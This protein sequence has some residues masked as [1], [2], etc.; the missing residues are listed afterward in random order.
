MNL[1]VC[2]IFL[3][4]MIPLKLFIEVAKTMN[5]HHIIT[6]MCLSNLNYSIKHNQAPGGMF[7]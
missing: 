1:N 4:C 6:S 7:V 2:Q 5:V 3:L